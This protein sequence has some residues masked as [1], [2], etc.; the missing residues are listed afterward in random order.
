MALCVDAALRLLARV[1]LAAG[2]RV[3]V[4]VQPAGAHLGWERKLVEAVSRNSIT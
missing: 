1:E 2:V 4:V 3:A